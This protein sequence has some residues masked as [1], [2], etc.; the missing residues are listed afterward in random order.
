MAEQTNMI[1]SRTSVK[2]I[3]DKDQDPVSTVH[4]PLDRYSRHMMTPKTTV[5]SLLAQRSPPNSL[6]RLIANRGSLKT[7]HASFVRNMESSLRQNKKN[8]VSVEEVDYG[9]EDAAPGSDDADATDYGYGDAS[10]DEPT[11]KKNDAPEPQNFNHK[12]EEPDAKR[13]RYQRR[14]SKT[15]AMLLAMMNAPLLLH[16]DFLDEQKGQ[17]NASSPSL[18]LSSGSSCL[19]KDT[20]EGGLEIAEELF[21]HLQKRRQSQT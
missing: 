12:A 17:Q 6:N 9:Y 13:R 8:E 3:A 19:P 7:V 4:K 15:P 16:L 18:S 2:V 20:W 5:T 14:N 10:P 11:N 21:K 1:P